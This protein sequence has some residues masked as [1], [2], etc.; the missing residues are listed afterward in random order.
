M[1][2]KSLQESNKVIL[3]LEGDK[4]ILKGELIGKDNE[5]A[6]MKAKYENAQKN[7]ENLRTENSE[8]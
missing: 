3:G 2:Q 6:E 8:L 4:E 7:I 5:L 1:Q